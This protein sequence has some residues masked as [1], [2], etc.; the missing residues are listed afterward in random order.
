MVVVYE[1]VN[2]RPKQ[3]E[4]ETLMTSIG[5]FMKEIVQQLNNM[6]VA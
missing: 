3:F 6:F 1:Q 2:G 5:T 4:H